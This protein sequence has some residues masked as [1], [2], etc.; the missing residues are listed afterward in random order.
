MIAVKLQEFTQNP[1]LPHQPDVEEPIFFEL[2]R[3][4]G[5][6]ERHLDLLEVFRAQYPATFF[7]IHTDQLISPQIVRFLQSCFK[8]GIE[9]SFRGPDWDRAID[10]LVEQVVKRRSELEKDLYNFLI[11]IDVNY[12]QLC[13]PG[14]LA[15]LFRR[16]AL[17]KFKYFFIQ[18][19]A[20]G[21]LKGAHGTK[22]IQ[23]LDSAFR[24]LEIQ[25][26]YDLYIYFSPHHPLAQSLTLKTR[27]TFS[28][29]QEVHIDLTNRCTHS[30][31]FCGLYS[32]LAIE[33][34][35]RNGGGTIPQNIRDFMVK[36][37]QENYVL[38][39][40]NSL[41]WTTRSIQFGGAGDPLLHPKAVD[42]ITLARKKGYWV[43]VLSNLEYLTDEK[44]NQLR[45][46]AN[47][48]KRES[49]QIIANVSGPNAD[50]YIKTRP[51]QSQ[52]TFNTVTTNISKLNQIPGVEVIIMCVTTELNFRSLLGFIEYCK[53]VGS[54]KLWIKPLEI[55][56][57]WMK[58]YAISQMDSLKEYAEILKK[59]IHSA[60]REGI[61]LF[62]RSILESLVKEITCV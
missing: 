55:H 9:F 49:L 31:H 15:E 43:Q 21:L 57:D 18:G 41:P 50:V 22:I 25:R 60:D 42:F 20:E 56:D 59:L 51:K 19:P 11:I 8:V 52:E 38:E 29:L 45:P 48:R 4:N 58:S 61:I 36:T 10:L 54:K 12:Q 30:C 28:G 46:Y 40:L 17:Y 47:P 24:L 34:F 27:L 6:I 26:I 44:I 32:P 13:S 39:V 35:K 7:Q 14:N 33:K 2:G 53:Q 23:F 5:F 16:I 37:I 62:Q 3:D 1:I